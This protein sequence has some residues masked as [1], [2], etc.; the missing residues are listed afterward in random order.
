MIAE[1]LRF[2]AMLL[3]LAGLGWAAK[4]VI[5][6]MPTYVCLY[7]PVDYLDN[8][9]CSW[10]R[11]NMANEERMMAVGCVVIAAV[12]TGFAILLTD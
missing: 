12:C 11:F 5:E 7:I 6:A 8:Q 1:A 4:L 9:W 10:T 3:T 2:T